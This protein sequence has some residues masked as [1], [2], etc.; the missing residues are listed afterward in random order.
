M[1]RSLVKKSIAPARG[2]PDDE[3]ERGVRAAKTL[4]GGGEQGADRAVQCDST[5]GEPPGE[6]GVP[7]EE[8]RIDNAVLAVHG[9]GEQ[10]QGGEGGD[11]EGTGGADGGLR[12]EHG[13]QVGVRG[14]CAGGGIGGEGGAGG[15]RRRAGAGGDRRG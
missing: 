12:V 8:G 2:N 6:W 1:S 4:T 5:A 15:G 14:E 7:R 13:G 3:G 11:H 10:D 9:E